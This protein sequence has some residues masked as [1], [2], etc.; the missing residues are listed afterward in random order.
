MATKTHW[1]KTFNKDYFGAHDLDD[2]NG[3]YSTADL[4]IQRVVLKDVKDPHGNSERVRVAEFQ[5]KA[6]PMILNVGACQQIEAFTGS[7]YIEDWSGCAIRVY[8]ERGVRAYG[9]EVDALRIAP[10]QPKERQE[11]TPDHEKW[12]GAVKKY[13]EDGA[14]AIAVIRKYYDLSETNLEALKDAANLSQHSAE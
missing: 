9:A 6:K 2:G 10:E 1:K 14:D 3:G 12:A 4:V 11:L 5:G 8:V 7:R 13:A